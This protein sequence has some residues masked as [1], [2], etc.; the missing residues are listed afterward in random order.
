MVSL[1]QSPNAIERLE[2]LTSRQIIE[3]IVEEDLESEKS[4]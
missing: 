4:K 2:A 1:S 3:D